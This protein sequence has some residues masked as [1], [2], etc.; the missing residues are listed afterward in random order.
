[1]KKN[2]SAAAC[3]LACAA[4]TLTFS[5]T[6]QSSVSKKPVTTNVTAAADSNFVTLDQANTAALEIPT[7][8]L[9]GNAMKTKQVDGTMA[10]VTREIQDYTVYPNTQTP[11]MYIFN[12]KG[13]GFVVIPADKRVHP[14][15]AISST[16]YFKI[17]DQL[18]DGLNDWLTVNHKNMQTLRQNTTVARPKNVD[19]M[20]ALLVPPSVNNSGK[21]IDKAAPPPPPCE[22]TSSTQ[23]AGPL[24]QTT[25]AQGVPYNQWSLMPAGTY[26][27][28][29]GKA[30]TGC[31]ATA[32]GQILY[33][34]QYPTSY[35]WS[36][37]PLTSNSYTA[38]G[39]TEVSRLMWNL[40]Q[41]VGMVYTPT[42]SAPASTSPTVISNALRSSYCNFSSASE[43][44]YSNTSSYP[45][46]MSNIDSR[47]PLI[48]IG[49]TQTDGHA[50][51]CDGYMQITSTW[52]PSNGNPGGG[53]TTLLFDMNWGWNEGPVP[54]YQTEPNVDG[55]YD[56][57]Q[58]EVY[59]GPTLEYFQ[60]NLAMIYN[61]HP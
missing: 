35:N 58:W 25:W 46:V 53:E 42:S 29:G 41:S 1:M 26:W 11:S 10:A 59:N 24:V 18:P 51:V 22:P 14:I 55:W 19:K 15:L 12:Y 40:G 17:S 45:T 31:V 28:G 52:C 43:A 5:C 33:Y 27:A 37:M 32:M 48:L 50:W 7:S 49:D 54:G 21:T 61:I 34:W 60:Y 23:Q 44:T 57:N 56:F 20:W 13:G 36:V 38:V 39:E 16:G 3:T 47:E 6:K 2:L 4:L 30:P 8:E 9:A